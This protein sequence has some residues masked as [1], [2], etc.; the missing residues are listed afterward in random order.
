MLKLPHRATIQN[1]ETI[2][3]GGGTYEE[4]WMPVVNEDDPDY[5]EEALEAAT[6]WCEAKPLSGEELYEAQK[7]Q[8]EYDYKVTMR[9]RSLDNSQRLVFRDKVLAIH[10]VIDPT[11][12]KRMLVVYCEHKA[13][14]E[15]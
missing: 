15:V 12:R 14:E 11:E 1:K 10:Y 3:T 2:D 4:K 8:A 6:V 13:G 5:N 9:Y 7:A